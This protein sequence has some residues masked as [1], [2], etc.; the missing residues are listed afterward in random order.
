VGGVP[1]ATL[2]L[3]K[4]RDGNKYFLHLTGI[5]I[6]GR[7]LFPSYRYFIEIVKIGQTRYIDV[8]LKSRTIR[9]TIFKDAIKVSVV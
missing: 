9:I 5:R 7:D 1:F 4:F 3:W 6:V 2:P 8:L